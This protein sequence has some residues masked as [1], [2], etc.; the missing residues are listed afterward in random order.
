[1]EP[2]RITIEETRKRMESGE[3]VLFVDVRN[4]KDWGASDVRLPGA[5][6]VPLAQLEQR[7]GELPR[8]RIVIAYCT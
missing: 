2:E 6:R 4:D 1:V 8:D 7:V 5:V 3:Q